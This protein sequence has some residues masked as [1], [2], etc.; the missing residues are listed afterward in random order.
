[1]AKIK[2]GILGGYKGR[3][4]NTVGYSLGNK[5]IVRSV[6]KSKRIIS[7]STMISKRDRM[8]ELG[9]IWEML[10]DNIKDYWIDRYEGRA[11][12]EYLKE[13][14]KFQ[15]FETSSI[16]ARVSY[17]PL[18]EYRPVFTKTLTRS[19]VDDI[20]ILV[21]SDSIPKPDGEKPFGF[22][23]R[24]GCEFSGSIF[25]SNWIPRFLILGTYSILNTEVLSRGK[26]F[27]A[28]GNINDYL[29]T[30]QSTLIVAEPK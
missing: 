1:M 14:L 19:L 17:S 12:S 6:S 3:I 7:S 5:S 16:I 4:D 23:Y 18:P 13:G 24:Q 30:S 27:I 21:R 29:G 28:N 11:Y 2:K 10:I 25:A 26:L 22:Y 15:T 9:Q 8:M 20:R